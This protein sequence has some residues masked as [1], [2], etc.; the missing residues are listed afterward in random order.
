[1][2]LKRKDNLGI[3]VEDLGS[4]RNSGCALPNERVRAAVTEA[5]GPR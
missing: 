2:A 4:P 5:I 1:M 3:V